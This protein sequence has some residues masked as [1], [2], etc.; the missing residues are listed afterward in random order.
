MRLLNHKKS[1][2]DLREKSK[3]LEKSLANEREENKMLV[4][5]IKV[6]DDTLFE[7]KESLSSEKEKSG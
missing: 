1:C 4:N 7:L 5:S 2:L 3:A 6:K